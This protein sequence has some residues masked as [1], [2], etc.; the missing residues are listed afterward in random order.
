MGTF[1]GLFSILYG[2]IYTNTVYNSALK[3]VCEGCTKTFSK[4]H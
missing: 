2:Y 3:E 4:E 1:I